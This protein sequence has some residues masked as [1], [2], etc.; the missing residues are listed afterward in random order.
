MTKQMHIFPMENIAS[1]IDM[2]DQKNT[3]EKTKRKSD[4]EEYSVNILTLSSF[5]ALALF[6][7]AVIP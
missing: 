5:P 1:S 3:P 6:L 7:A 4:E 2:C